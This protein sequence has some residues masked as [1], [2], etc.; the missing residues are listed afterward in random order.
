MCVPECVIQR[1]TYPSWHIVCSGGFSS[2]LSHAA[3][4][5]QRLG[6]GIMQDALSPSLSFT[7]IRIP[8]GAGYA[9]SSLPPLHHRA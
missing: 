7:C 6:A 9:L 2:T 8:E 5:Q 3:R 1:A 4:E